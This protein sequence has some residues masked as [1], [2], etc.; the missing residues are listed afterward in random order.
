[1]KSN[2]TGKYILDK[3]GRP[4]PEPDVEKWG[5]WFETAKRHIGA[6][7]LR[8]YY[9]STIFLGLD[10]N[11]SQKGKPI[12][13]ET[14]VFY[15]HTKRSSRYNIDRRFSSRLTAKRYHNSIVRWLKDHRSLKGFGEHEDRKG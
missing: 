15:K 1:M 4:V 5:R 10:Y 7:T 14:M 9:V 6:D 8:G 3:K 12:L 11:F 2:I 13:W